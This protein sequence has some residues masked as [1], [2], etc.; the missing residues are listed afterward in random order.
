MFSLSKSR[1]RPVVATGFLKYR[2][3]QVEISIDQ[4]TRRRSTDALTE[5]SRLVDEI[6]TW[7]HNVFLL[8]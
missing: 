6:A 4:K 1:L 7:I 5:Y 2:S 8:N 3:L